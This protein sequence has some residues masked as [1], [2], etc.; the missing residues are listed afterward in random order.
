MKTINKARKEEAYT[1]LETI[2]TQTRLARANASDLHVDA[3]LGQKFD[4][5]FER[6]SAEFSEV[7]GKTY[8]D[9]NKI[10]NRIKR[11]QRSR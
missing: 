9:L 5:L 8:E 2:L 7:L 10:I 6:E 11:Y 1:R 3:V 4:F